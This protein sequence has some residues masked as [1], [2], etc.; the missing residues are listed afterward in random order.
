M[1]PLVDSCECYTCKNHTRSYI[2]HLVSC[3]ELTGDVLLT[4]HNIHITQAFGARLELEKKEGTLAEF[5][6]W[7][8][9]TQTTI[10]FKISE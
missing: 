10:D 4:L 3:N 1:S 7:Y 8:V 2:H 6:S 9:N 5:V